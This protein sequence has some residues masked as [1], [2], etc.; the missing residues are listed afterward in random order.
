MSVMRL[1]FLANL[2]SHPVISGFITAS[3]ILIAASQVKHILGIAAGGDTLPEIVAEVG[4]AMST[5]NPYTLAL[6]GGAVVDVSVL[7][8]VGSRST[9]F[10]NVENLFDD[11]YEVGRTPV[12]T[13]GQPATLH[14][15]VRLALP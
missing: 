8:A 5:T 3:G 4:V 13:Y 6:G 1:V 11:A 10:V 2:L 14:L 9:V 15:G 12:A 7:K